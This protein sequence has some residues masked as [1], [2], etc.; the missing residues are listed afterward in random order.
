MGD[1][2][3][4]KGFTLIELLVV[5]AII[6]ILAA[7]LFPVFAKAREKALA[8]SC[9]S[10]LKQLGLSLMM[11]HQDYD[12]TLLFYYVTSGPPNGL[13]GYT[14]HD[15]MFPRSVLDP[16]LK[17]TGI[18]HDPS[19][20]LAGDNPND[21]T[22]YTT[23]VGC[24]YS[25]NIGAGGRS[26][27][28]ELGFNGWGMPYD[29]TPPNGPNDPASPR[30]TTN[31]VNYPA[32]FLTFADSGTAAGMPGVFCGGAWGDQPPTARHQGNANCLFFDGH[33]KAVN[34]SRFNPPHP[35]PPV[36]QRMWWR[37][38]P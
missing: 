36:T 14:M 7:I 12:E 3:S 35:W 32:E 16:Y 20:Q 22:N 23:Y 11:Y 1:V 26:P 17:N 27:M 31:Q 21:P 28:P 2:R 24:H 30:G 15:I 8:T 9:L 4:C 10:N 33:A 19:I 25:I 34:G 38:T 13:S 5:I 6:A 37:N 18:A 29:M